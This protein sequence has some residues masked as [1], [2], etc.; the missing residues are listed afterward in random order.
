VIRRPPA[1]PLIVFALTG[2][3]GS[4][5]LLGVGNPLRSLFVLPFLIAAPGL[6]LVPLARIGGWPGLTMAVGLSLALDSLVPTIMIYAGFW[7]PNAT[8]A[9]LVLVSLVGATAQLLTV[10]FVLG[11]MATEEGP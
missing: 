2:A 11:G 7:S 5:V 1:V 8:L 9:V 6:A 10:A 4:V 3:A